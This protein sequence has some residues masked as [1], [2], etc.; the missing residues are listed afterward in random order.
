M[1]K[2]KQ[3]DENKEVLEIKH[4]LT[5]MKNAFDGLFSKLDTARKESMNLKM[6]QKKLPEL[7]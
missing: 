7:K 3:R 6:G 5:E 4:T 1:G 2:V